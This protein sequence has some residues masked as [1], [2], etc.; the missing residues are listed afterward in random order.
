MAQLFGMTISMLHIYQNSIKTISFYSARCHL[1][2]DPNPIITTWI[3]AEISLWKE[4]CISRALFWKILTFFVRTDPV[5]P[6]QWNLHHMLY[7]PHTGHMQNL[8]GWVPAVH[9]FQREQRCV[10]SESTTQQSWLNYGFLD[11]T[12][13]LCFCTLFL[14]FCRE[15]SWRVAIELFRSKA[16]RLLAT[17]RGG[18]WLNLEGG[19]EK[20][21]EILMCV[22]AA[23]HFFCAVFSIKFCV[24]LTMSL[25]TPTGM[26]PWSKHLHLLQSCSTRR[27]SSSYRSPSLGVT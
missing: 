25:C 10:W 6:L 13:N 11:K 19:G 22:W 14:G 16:Q 9:E 5:G 21:T 24:F 4:V 26:F 27:I 1:S 3:P 7:A 15:H 8:E 20:F 17:Y 18:S 12:Q 2:I 23:A